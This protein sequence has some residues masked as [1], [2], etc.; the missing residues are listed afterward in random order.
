MTKKL[1]LIAIAAALSFGSQIQAQT[2]A[3][4]APVTTQKVWFVKVNQGKNQEWL[5]LLR[6][7]SMKTAQVRADAG[8]I[9]SW[10]VLRS[11][12]PAGEEA[13][14]DY[15]ISE[16]SAGNPKSGGMSTADQYKKAGITMTV[17]EVSAKRNEL[18]HLVA[19]EL[20]RPRIYNGSAHKGDYL[21]VN[22][23]KV[24]DEKS[25]ADL[26]RNVWSPLSQEWIKQGAMTGWLY[27]TKMLPSGSDT[28]YTTRT[29]DM[30][31]SLEAVYADR[32]FDDTFAKVHPGKKI[33]D[34]M[35]QMEKARDL[36]RRELWRVVERVT[37][38]E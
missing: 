34:V 1:L 23:M 37:K 9:I 29:V 26:E 38:K 35:A 19:S 32:K 22:Y 5:K 33:D 12:Y 16:I 30:Y 10:T 7:V 8:E 17:E 18:S 11:E 13:R 6:E 28:V 31:P 25:Y 15:M 14:A 36:G 21:T 27:A 3:A 4:A 20:W 2:T 24:H